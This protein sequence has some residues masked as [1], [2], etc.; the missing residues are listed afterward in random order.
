MP[1]IK[2]IFTLAR[3]LFLV[4]GSEVIVGNAIILETPRAGR[5]HKIIA[6]KSIKFHSRAPK[7]STAIYQVLKEEIEAESPENILR[8]SRSMNQKKQGGYYNYAKEAITLVG[9]IVKNNDRKSLEKAIENLWSDVD[10]LM[11][12]EQKGDW[13]SVYV[14]IPEL[15]H[16]L[17]EMEK[18]FPNSALCKEYLPS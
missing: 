13:D 5:R 17:Q 15:D 16:W 12:G 18:K 14:F 6:P 1:R 2:P 8:I 7:P 3:Q 9:N 10:A 4:E 11:E